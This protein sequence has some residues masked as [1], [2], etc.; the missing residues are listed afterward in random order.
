MARTPSTI[1]KYK[2]VAEIAKGGMGAVYKAE[3]PTLDRHVIIKKL[4]LRGDASMRERFRREARIMMDFKND[5]IVDV[6]DHFREG[7]SYYIVLEYVDGVSLDQLLRTERYLPEEIALYIFRDSCRALRYAH[8]RGVVHRDI[9]PANIL[10]SRTG[11]VKLVDFG[12]ASMHED[13]DSGL[14]REGMTLGTPS[15]MAP[16]QF[17]NTHAV[18]RRADIYSVGVMLYEMVTG[19]KPFPGNMT[20]EAIRLI[21]HGKYTRARKINPKVSRFTARLIRRCMHAKPKRRFQELGAVLK[22]LDR[23]FSPK[24]RESGDTRIAAFLAGKWEPLKKRSPLLVAAP[25]AAALL[26]AVL[27]GGGFWAWQRGYHYDYLLPDDAGAFRATVRIPKTDARLSDMLLRAQLFAADGAEVPEVTGIDLSFTEVPELET[28][29]FRVFQTGRLFQPPGSYRLKVSAGDQ[30][31]W[32]SFFLEPRTVQRRAAAT[33]GELVLEFALPDPR[34]MP[35][36]VDLQVRDRVTGRRLPDAQVW[37]RR[38]G[39]W[40][41]FL[42]AQTTM[43]TGDAIHAFRIAHNGFF[44]SEYTLRVEPHQRTMVL[45]ARLQPIPGAVR[46]ISAEVGTPLLLDG[47]ETYL[48]SGRRPRLEA[49]GATGEA[50]IDLVLVPGRYRLTA[51]PRRTDG[52]SIEIDVEPGRRLTVYLEDRASGLAFRTGERVIDQS[53]GN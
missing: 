16:E 22:R 24:R 20:A 14:T 23:A 34:P 39:R 15:Y 6:Y 12:I 10:L 13:T 41:P 49:V 8:A 38:Q 44:P 29:D 3:H 43:L 25:V 53:I 17:E 2:V 19:K 40:T 18:D 5:Y 46:I 1:G 48:W 35:L 36:L 51:A 45:D 9:K 37:V 30:L 32:R 33:A 31:F 52:A 21:Q 47:E 42:G 4:T 11:H 28:V 27:G 50:P 7:S 26:L